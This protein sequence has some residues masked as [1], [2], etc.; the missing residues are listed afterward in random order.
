M[1]PTTTHPPAAPA[2]TVGSRQSGS[3]EKEIWNMKHAER[4]GLFNIA[5]ITYSQLQGPRAATLHFPSSTPARGGHGTNV[6][7]NREQ[8]VWLKLK[9]YQN[10]V[11]RNCSGVVKRLKLNDMALRNSPIYN[12]DLFWLFF[13][14]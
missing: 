12:L 11:N 2:N 4:S 7:N 1:L 8:R 5:H 13:C 10:E 9:L 6:T 14:P 3:G